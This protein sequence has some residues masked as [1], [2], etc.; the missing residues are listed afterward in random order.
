MY[1]LDDKNKLGEQHYKYGG[2]I[3]NYKWIGKIPNE[4]YKEEDFF[5]RR[6][7]LIEHTVLV[8]YST[9]ICYGEHGRSRTGN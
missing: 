5:Y 7:I 4:G 1:L 3:P 8:L 2:K 6:L 9:R